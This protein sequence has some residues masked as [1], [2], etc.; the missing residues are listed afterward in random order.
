MRI[1]GFRLSFVLPS[2]KTMPLLIGFPAYSMTKITKN[3]G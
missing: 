2:A 1:Y 3:P